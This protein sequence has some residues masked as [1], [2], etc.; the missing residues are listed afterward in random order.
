MRFLLD[1]DVWAATGRFLRDLGHDALPVADI[2]LAAADDEVLLK[3]AHQQGRIF[4]T[5]DRD[6]GNLVFVKTLGAGVLY[7]RML[8][9]TQNIVHRQLYRP[10]SGIYI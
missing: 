9:S 5:R 10:T 6:Y 4:V 1:Q 2:G 3:T 8:P 7:L